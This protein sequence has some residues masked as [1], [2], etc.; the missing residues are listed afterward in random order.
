MSQTSKGMFI[1]KQVAKATA[2]EVVC[3]DGR[4]AV[5]HISTDSRTVQPDSVF[6]AL[7]GEHFD[8]GRFCVQ[9]A[10]AGARLLLVNR[11]VWTAGRLDRL[12]AQTQVVAVDDTLRALGDLAAWHRRRLG[13]KLIAITGSNGKT[14]TKEMVAWVL[15][16][17]P[18]VLYNHGNYNN[19]IGMPRSLLRLRPQHRYAVMEMGMN[20]PGE[21]LRL[22]DIADPQVAVVTNVHPVHLEGLGSIQAVADA[23]GELLE[24]LDPAGTVVLNADDPYVLQMAHRTQARKMLYGYSPAAD[25]RIGQVKMTSAGLVFVLGVEATHVELRLPHLGVH[26]ASN[27]AA[28]FC[29]G[30]LLGL[31]VDE[32]SN[33]LATA[34]SPPMRMEVV[35]LGPFRLLVDCYNANPRSVQA[36]LETLAKMETQTRLAI[37]GDMLELGESSKQLHR[38]VGLGVAEAKLDALCTYGEHAKAIAEGARE[39]GLTNVHHAESM[40]QVLAWSRRWLCDDAWLLLKGSRGMRL[41]RVVERL[42]EEH[43][44]NWQALLHQ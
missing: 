33:R 37:L 27:A 31:S 30:L 1:A 39:A 4:I 40:E 3:G 21:I 23:K 9:A 5:S 34:P 26:Q 19:L 41:E 29:V 8:G 42:C 43:K 18:S 12:P 24:R 17:E 16:G 11:T 25:V 15:G 10:E 38:Q 28:A 44:V 22:A 32:I 2:G 7:A 14:S 6:I 13:A 20:R 36:A 35:D